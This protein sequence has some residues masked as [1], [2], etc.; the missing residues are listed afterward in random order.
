MASTVFNSVPNFAQAHFEEAP[1]LDDLKLSK[2]ARRTSSIHSSAR[3]RELKRLAIQAHDHEREQM[4]FAEEIKSLRGVKHFRWPDL[5]NIRKNESLWPS[6]TRYWIGIFYQILSD[7]GRSMLLPLAW[8]AGTTIFFTCFYLDYHLE[9]SHPPGTISEW[10][11]GVKMKPAFAELSCLN[12]QTSNP[13]AAA[14]YLAIHNGLVFSGL[15]R[16]SKLEQSYACLYGES[17]SSP[18]IPDTIAFMSVLQTLL[19]AV[20]IFLLL[21]AVRNQFRIR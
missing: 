16:S 2:S 7:F 5:C 3:W 4:F 18:L 11:I 12:E 14:A 8:W 9:S 15:G 19:S 20:L 21:L 13:L 17:S 1:R 10:A 6:G